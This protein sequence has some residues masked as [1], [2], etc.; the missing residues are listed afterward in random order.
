MS[1]NMGT[2]LR[3]RSHKGP[4][5]DLPSGI[6][7]YYLEQKSFHPVT[8]VE[9]TQPDRHIHEIE[10]DTKIDGYFQSESLICP[11]KQDL[12]SEFRSNLQL[13][14][15]PN[16]CVINLRGG[17]YRWIP[18]VLLSSRF[19]SQAME[20][21]RDLNP[22]VEFVVIT[23]DPALARSYFQDTRIE[24]KS[25]LPKS[26]RIRFRRSSNQIG[27]DFTWLQRAKYLILSNSSFSW[28]GA[29][30]NEFDPVVIAPKYWAAHNISDGYWALGDSLT[31]N[32]MWL[33][34]AGNVTSYE[35]CKAELERYAAS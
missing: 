23:D 18:N 5:G 12:V 35:T 33:D 31:K 21:I 20:Y 26:R 22:R 25:V 27:H 28:W 4:S 8:G 30:T 7:N 3:G 1:P 10:P 29:W 15:D 32:W 24:S 13:E 6:R 16:I 9:L 19:Y 2:P 34:R 17:E 14:I 11:I